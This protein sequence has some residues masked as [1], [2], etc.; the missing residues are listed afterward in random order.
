MQSQN[1]MFDDFVKV[2]NGAAGTFAGMTREAE[3]AFRERMREWI[4]GLDMV[5]REEFEAVKAIAVAA[6]EESAALKSRL[7]ALEAAAPAPAAAP[8]KPRRKPAGAGVAGQ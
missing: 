2:L 6:R 3:T 5:G 7:D 1:R 8:P 4:G